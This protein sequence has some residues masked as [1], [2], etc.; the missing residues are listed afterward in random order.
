MIPMQ[1]VTTAQSPASTALPG[2]T[3]SLE[4]ETI[5]TYYSIV[6]GLDVELPRSRIRSL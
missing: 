6:H 2:E 5:S 1:A 4:R 3:H